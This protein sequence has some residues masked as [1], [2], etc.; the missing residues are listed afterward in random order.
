MTQR[1][2]L[3]QAGR[4]SG[5]RIAGWGLLAGLLALPAVTGAPWSASDFILMG[6]LLAGLGL[7]FELIAAWSASVAYRAGAALAV[8][9]AFL[10]LWVNLAVGMVGAPNNPFNLAFGGV[11]LV[12]LLGSILARFAP[13]GMVRAMAATALAQAAAGA[14]GLAADPRG[15]LF[16]MLFAGAWLLAAALFRSAAQEVL[17]ERA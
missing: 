2:Q 9:T 13:A 1:D 15:G 3:R 8:V 17:A 12:A 4:W 10:T 16:A 6:V 7:G 5:W 11:L 14:A